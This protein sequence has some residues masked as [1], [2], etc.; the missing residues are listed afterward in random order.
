MQGMHPFVIGGDLN[1]IDRNT[2]FT[3]AVSGSE[4]TAAQLLYEMRDPGSKL[5]MNNGQLMLNPL[6]DIG[7]GFTHMVC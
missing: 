2:N 3:M 5:I 4:A 6:D 7:T 1:G